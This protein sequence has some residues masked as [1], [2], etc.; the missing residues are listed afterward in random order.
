MRV[1]IEKLC[2]WLNPNESSLNSLVQV[3]FITQSHSYSQLLLYNCRLITC[4]RLYVSRHRSR[5][6]VIHKRFIQQITT[7]QNYQTRTCHVKAN[8]TKYTQNYIELRIGFILWT[9]NSKLFANCKYIFSHKLRA[10]SEVC[11]NKMTK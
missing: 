3:E 10:H 11:T 9:Y 4:H 1:E 2:N 7:H 5:R 6:I 8:K